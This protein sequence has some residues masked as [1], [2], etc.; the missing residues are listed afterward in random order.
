MVLFVQIYDKEDNS[1][2]EIRD[3]IKEK[4]FHKVYLLTGDQGYSIVQAKKLLLSALVADGDEM[5]FAVYKGEKVDLSELAATASTFPFFA[6]KRVIELDRTQVL[7]EDADQLIG[8]LETLPETSCVILIEPDI[9]KRSKVYKWIKKNE[10][11]AEFSVNRKLDT[12]TVK[13]IAAF[14]KR[15][16]KQIREVDAHAIAQRTGN[17]LFDVKNEVD[18][19]IAYAGDRNVIE[20]EDIDAVIIR[21][22]E[23]HIF[24]MVDAIASGNRIKAMEC[25]DQLLLL[26]ES[27][28]RTIVLLYKHFRRLYIIKTMSQAGMPEER[29]V[30][31]SGVRSFAL[32]RYY[33]Q[34]RRFSTERIKDSMEQC[35]D[36]DRSFKAGEISD[37]L[38]C[39]S[40]IA[41][42][43]A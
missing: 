36:T 3:N 35:L 8:I 9:D 5:N 15:A 30:S 31:Q 23:D 1:L 10:Y 42:L 43:M 2:K 6:Q 32:K 38:A 7:K 26:K 21:E 37:Q 13:A 19:L 34:L 29:I 41:R 14:L 16:G 18:K 20:A 28:A 40:L 27:P 11:V 12:D 33:A 25:Y 17:D 22:A 4:N 24:E 39:E